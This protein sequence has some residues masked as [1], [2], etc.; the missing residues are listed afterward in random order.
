MKT[1]TLMSAVVAATAFGAFADFEIDLDPKTKPIKDVSTSTRGPE[2]GYGNLA[3]RSSMGATEIPFTIVPLFIGSDVPTDEVVQTLRGVHGRSGISRFVLHAPGHAVRLTGYYDAEGYRGLGRRIKD[4]QDQVRADGI[5]V[6][7]LMGPTMNVGIRHPW[8]QFTFANGSKRGF[9]AC[10]G[11][12]AF[13]RD[14]AERCAAM[15]AECKPFLFMM[16]DDYRFWGS[17]CFCTNHLARFSRQTGTD[18][19]AETLTKA[20]SI[21]SNTVLR[22]AWNDLQVGDLVT[23]A[24]NVEKAIH[25][26]SPSTRIGIS[27]PGGFRDDATARIARTL[28]GSHDRPFVRWWGTVY[29]YDRPL[30]VSD[31]LF[32]ARWAKENVSEGIDCVYEADAAPN[33]V[34]YGSG[35]RLGASCSSVLAAGFDGLWYWAISRVGGIADGE[36]MPNLEGYERSSRRWAALQD[37]VK[38]G[39]TV[40]VSVAFNPRERLVSSSGAAMEHPVHPG[41]AARMLGRMGL[42]YTTRPGDVTIYA[43]YWAFEGM[44]DAEVERILS[45]NVFLDG[46]AAEALSERGFVNLIGVA[47]SRRAGIDFSGEFVSA[48]GMKITST[49]H[50]DYGLDGAAVLMLKA[51]GAETLSHYFSNSPKKAVQPALTRFTNERGGRI[52][53][54]AVALANCTATNIYNSRKRAL[55]IEAFEWLGGKDVFPARTEKDVNVVVTANEDDAKTRLVIHAVNLSCDVRE[56]LSFEVVEAYRGSTVEILDGVSWRMA[57]VM[58]TNGRLHVPIRLGVFDDLVIRLRDSR[59]KTPVNM[60]K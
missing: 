20:L 59:V 36:P 42:A 28:S 22:L 48:T 19:T 29:G 24:A 25:A 52:V 10:A 27:A 9:T 8:T 60:K 50:Q 30:D 45:G 17:G 16:E 18:W 46:E 56:S 33:T 7:F 49:F 15:A 40:G 35:A 51:R 39:H 32:S 23:L 14:F 1:K 37:A 13:Q 26:V 53:V 43:G 21:S 4:I 41:S 44:S 3:K 54:M 5:E 58:W 11:D 47:A 12:L 34:F 57:K 38:G 55:L 6:G 31:V 2:I